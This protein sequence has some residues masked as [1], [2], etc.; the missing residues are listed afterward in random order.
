MSYRITHRH[1]LALVSVVRE[2]LGLRLSGA[3]CRSRRHTAGETALPD[4]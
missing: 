1:G 2:L 4:G 3:A